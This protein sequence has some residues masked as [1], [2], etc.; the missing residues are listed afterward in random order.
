MV[1]RLRNTTKTKGPGVKTNL[2]S[3][4]V[5]TTD[6]NAISKALRA[7]RASDTPLTEFPGR[8]PETLDTAYAIQ[9]KSIQAWPD[10]VEGWKVGG[11][12]P[13]FHSKFSERRL[14]GP[15]FS[16]T[17][18][19]APDKGALEVPAY[20]GFVAVEAE[21]VFELGDCSAIGETDLTMDDVI[22]AIR[23]AYIGVELASSPIIDINSYGPSVII[24]DFGNNFGLVIGQRIEDW[25][26]EALSRVVA[27]V[28]I[29]GETVGRKAALPGLDGPLGAVKFLIE[30][31]RA[32][33]ESDLSGLYVSSGAIT[34]VHDSKIGASST[35]TFEG[36]GKIDLEIVPIA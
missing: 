14:A 11:V 13:A 35:V 1:A 18:R 24:S 29:D 4:D 30:Y 8:I 22:S 36:I 33:G 12:P 9:A 17:V 16:K 34:G 6:V 27:S 5:E 25:S 23:A 10:Q 7:A 26:S 28:E 21:W 31:L 2:S 3:G 19:R 20:Q 15:I 32:N